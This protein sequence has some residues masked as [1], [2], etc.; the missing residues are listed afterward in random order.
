MFCVTNVQYWDRKILRESLL[1]IS[2][3]LANDPHSPVLFTVAIFPEYAC[4]VRIKYWRS[5]SNYKIDILHEF[6]MFV[7][8]DT[9]YVY[10]MTNNQQSTCIIGGDRDPKIDLE[11]LI[12]FCIWLWLKMFGW[13]GQE[14]PDLHPVPQTRPDEGRQGARILGRLS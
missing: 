11:R 10:Y 9:F 14:L 7:L 8:F 13:A 6:Y 4:K 2:R 5:H 12:E 3:S 1:L